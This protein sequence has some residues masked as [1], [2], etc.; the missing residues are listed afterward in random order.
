LFDPSEVAGHPQPTGPADGADEGRDRPV[1]AAE[2]RPVKAGRESRQLPSD[3]DPGG[4]APASLRDRLAA[5][6]LDLLALLLALGLLV[7]VSS[8][9]GVDVRLSDLPFYLPTWIAFGFFYQVLPLLFWGRTPGMKWA[10]IESRDDDG[11]PLTLQ[12]A[13]L[14]WLV[15]LVTWLLLGLP[16]LLALTGR[17][18]TDRVSGSRTLAST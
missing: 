8:A 4:T 9:M 2:T 5:A 10:G 18:L 7:G 6:A 1:S 3:R 14:R 17:S 13:A 16:G 11:E 15:G 12:Q